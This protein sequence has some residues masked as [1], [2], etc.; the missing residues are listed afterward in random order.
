MEGTRREGKGGVREGYE[1]SKERREYRQIRRK[2]RE[3]TVGVYQ[4][5]GLY[6]SNGLTETSFLLIPPD[7]S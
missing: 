7:S 5:C 4:C 3:V 2:Q 6:L 1:G